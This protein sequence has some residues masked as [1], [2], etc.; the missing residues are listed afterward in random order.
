METADGHAVRLIYLMAAMAKVGRLLDD[1]AM[2][3]AAERVWRDIVAHRMYITGNV[4]STVVGEAFTYDDDL[5]NDAGYGETCASV[6]MV[7][8]GAA[9]MEA[10]PSASIGDVIET[11]LFNGVLAGVALDGHSYFYVNPLEADPTAS[12]QNPT[13]RHVLTRRAGWFD[14]ACCPAN[15]TRLVTSLDRYLYTVHEDVIYA[16]QFVGNTADFGEDL[17]V[18]QVQA[19][20]GYPWTGEIRFEVDNPGRLDRRL[21][22]RIPGWAQGWTLQVDG[23]RVRPEPEDGF[24][25]VDI[26][27]AHTEIGL[28]LDMTSRLVRAA[29][30]VREDVG[31][32]AIARGPV[33]YT[34]EEADNVAPLW[35]DS[36]SA[37]AA[38]REAYEPDLLG[39]VVA[40]D[41]DGQ[42]IEET[43]PDDSLCRTAVG[44]LPSRS[45]NLR[46]IPY[47]AW[48]NRDEGQMAVWIREH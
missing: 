4:G 44:S 10:R 42:R 40:L 13:K 15:L 18:R 36:V 32:L 22:V 33:V 31:Q 20:V 39:G 38:V 45:T 19:G 9:L 43:G 24:V 5:P 27:A 25:F 16:H 6:G 26:G 23:Q 46:M 12:L 48:A 8:Y 11:E 29:P 14:C 1:P 17:V 35:L 28:S 41:V 34:R 3:A 37:A 7:F 47:F 21:A 2:L 30:R